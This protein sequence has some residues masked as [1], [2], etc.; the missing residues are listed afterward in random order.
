MRKKLAWSF[1]IA[2]I[3]AFITLMFITI[4]IKGILFLIAMFAFAILFSTAIKEV[5]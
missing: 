5:L 1:I 4:G 3:I 2:T